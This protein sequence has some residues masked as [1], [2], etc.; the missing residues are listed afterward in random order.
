M[1]ILGD[2]LIDLRGL[3]SF[4]DFMLGAYAPGTQVES[5]RLAI[6]GDGGRVNIGYPATVGA[7]LGMTDIMT[8]Q[9]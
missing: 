7:A 2:R 5:F 8:E 9:G 6:Y 3:Y 1:E 4:R